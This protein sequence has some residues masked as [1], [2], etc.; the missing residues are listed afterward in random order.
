MRF[1]IIGSAGHQGAQAQQQH[2]GLV[3]AKTEQ[4]AARFVARVG[5]Q[6]L[7]GAG[8]QQVHQVRV[9]RLGETVNQLADQQVGVQFEAQGAELAA[10][11]PFRMASATARAPRKPVTI[12][13]TVV[14]LTWP[15][16]SPTR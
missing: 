3:Q 13:P 1:E 4:E 9:V 14:T 10:E 11:P 5:F 2:A 15:A 7:A 16:A 8:I 6:V 12:P